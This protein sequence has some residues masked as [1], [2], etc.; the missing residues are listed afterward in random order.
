MPLQPEAW[1]ALNSL[2]DDNKTL[3]LPTGAC[4]RNGGASFYGFYSTFVPS[5]SWQVDR[6]LHKKSQTRRRFCTG[7]TVSL[8]EGTQLVFLAETRMHEPQTA[9]TGSRLA[10]FQV[11][12]RPFGAVLH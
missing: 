10:A 8:P 2:L 11:I 9:A 5:L 12:K 1:E 6:V 4:G 7:E 3:T